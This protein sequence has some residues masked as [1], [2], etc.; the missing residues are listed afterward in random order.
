METWA[1]SPGGVY[2]NNFISKELMDAATE[3]TELINWCTPVSGFGKKSGD[4]V[5]LYTMAGPDEVDDGI[6]QENVN[7]PEQPMALTGTSFQIRELGKAVTWTNIWNDWS[8]FELP[9]FAKKRLRNQMK[10]ILDRGAGNGF[11]QAGINFTP[12]GL[13]V[14]TVNLGVGVP[15]V[16]TVPPAATLGVTHI[17]ILRDYLYGTLKAPYFKEGDAYIGVCNWAETRHLRNDPLWQQWYVVGHPEKLQ[18]GEIGTIDN[19][20]IIETNHDTVLQQQVIAGVTYGQCMFFGDEAVAFAEAQTPELRLSPAM[21]SGRQFRC[22]WY[23]QVGFGV[24]H[25]GSLPRHAR[26]IRVSGTGYAV[27]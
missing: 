13:G 2:R 9:D 22:A 6:L 11:K 16:P 27:V 21:D 4:T 15:A 7:I 20:K 19:C 23:G 10:L 12:T 26:I 14:F 17:N 25:P 8:K 1:A 5:N 24:Y 18:R 3:K